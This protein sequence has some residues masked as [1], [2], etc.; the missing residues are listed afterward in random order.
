MPISLK[1]PRSRICV[2]LTDDRWIVPYADAMENGRF[3]W[4]LESNRFESYRWFQLM[5]LVGLSTNHNA[6]G[7][8]QNEHA[9]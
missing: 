3:Q 9:S 8:D 7:C 1:T 2:K 4:G 6:T 5:T